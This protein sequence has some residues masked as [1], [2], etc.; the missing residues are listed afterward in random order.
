MKKRKT[1]F[2]WIAAQLRFFFT[3]SVFWKKHAHTVLKRREEKRREEKRR[4]EKRREEKRREEKRR[5]EK[6]REEKR[7]EV[8]KKM[9]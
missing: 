3:C 1:P 6:R 4:E 7:R 2:V 5:E 9:V 8:S